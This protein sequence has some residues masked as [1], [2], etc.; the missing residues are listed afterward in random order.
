MATVAEIG[1]QLR[2]YLAQE[3]TLNAFNEWL[4]LNTWNLHQ[5]PVDVQELTG[6]IELALAE[7]SNG[8]LT[9]DELRAHFRALM[10]AQR[11]S[12]GESRASNTSA[13]S[14]SR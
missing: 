10:E 3:Q 12:V 2:R 11:V 13:N 6:E 14:S 8:H 4:T 9:Q 5:Q 7:F 1:D